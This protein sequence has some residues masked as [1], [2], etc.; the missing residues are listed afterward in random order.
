MCILS[1]RIN[2]LIEYINIKIQK[3]LTMMGWIN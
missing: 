3:V 1:I 2:Y